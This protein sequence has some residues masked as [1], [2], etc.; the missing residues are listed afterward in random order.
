M[1][2]STSVAAV[3]VRKWTKKLLDAVWSTE[4]FKSV[5]DPLS[6]PCRDDDEDKKK[7]DQLLKDRCALMRSGSWKE[8]KDVPFLIGMV[9]VVETQQE[10][11][12]ERDAWVKVLMDMDEDLSKED[13]CAFFVS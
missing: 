12:Q 10:V 1:S 7:K 8:D 13:A 5:V 3:V 2:S 9:I 4:E 11:E 6:L